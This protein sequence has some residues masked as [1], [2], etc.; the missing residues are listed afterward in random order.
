MTIEGR[1]RRG[2]YGDPDANN[3]EERVVTDPKWQKQEPPKG[4]FFKFENIGDAIEGKLLEIFESEF[5]GKKSKNAKLLSD[6]KEVSFRLSMQLEEYF[7]T[8]EVG[9]EI[10]IVY[11]GKKHTASGGTFKTFDFYKA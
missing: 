6:G 10:R 4:K 9:A 2:I 7:G 1:T 5:K 8:V 3:V 11:A